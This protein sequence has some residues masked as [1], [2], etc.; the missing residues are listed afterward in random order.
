MNL[1]KTADIECLPKSLIID[2]MYPN[3]L[4]M[5][6]KKMFIKIGNTECLPKSLFN[7]QFLPKSTK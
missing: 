2:Q 5:L 3:Q 1:S 6:D 7:D 4:S